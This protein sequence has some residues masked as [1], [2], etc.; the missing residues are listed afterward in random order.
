MSVLHDQSGPTTMWT[1]ANVAEA[2]PGLLT[3]L[4]WSLWISARP[5]GIR[6]STT[7]G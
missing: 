2:I 6:A 4:T 5:R 1:T 3:P 7:R